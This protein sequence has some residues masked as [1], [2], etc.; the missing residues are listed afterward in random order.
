M[1]TILEGL[2]SYFQHN[3]IEQIK[4]DWA[5][6]IEFDKIGPKIEDFITQSNYFYELEATGSYWEYS[7]ASKII[8]NPEFTPD[9]FLI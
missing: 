3:S 4:K 9:F 8:K 1:K 5:E 6:T 7:C 2:K